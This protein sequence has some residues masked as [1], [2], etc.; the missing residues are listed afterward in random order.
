MMTLNLKI[1]KKEDKL[2]MSSDAG[3]DYCDIY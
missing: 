1:N 2:I 3:G